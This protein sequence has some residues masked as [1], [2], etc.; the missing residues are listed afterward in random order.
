MKIHERADKT[1]FLRVTRKMARAAEL[2]WEVEEERAKG[3]VVRDRYARHAK[4]FGKCVTELEMQL[5]AATCYCLD[6]G[7]EYGDLLLDSGDALCAG[8][9]HERL[10]PDCAGCGSTNVVGEALDGATYCGACGPE[11]E[12]LSTAGAEEDARDD[13]DAGR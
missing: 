13:W 2:A 6:C 5:D 8:C 12:R 1:A 9:A 4:R 10:L 11:A 3:Q 7:K